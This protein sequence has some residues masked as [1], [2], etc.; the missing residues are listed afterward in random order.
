[1][2]GADRR[3]RFSTLE[4]TL[5]FARGL[6]RLLAQGDIVLLEG[7]LGAGKTELARAII[8]ELVGLPIAVPSPTFSLV[9]TYDAPHW[10]IA[11][12]DLYR[13][14]DP[15]EVVELG[16]EEFS[17]LGVLIV[18]WPSRAGEGVFPATAILIEM[19]D[20]GGEHREIY[21]RSSDEG[22]RHRLAVILDAA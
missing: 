6:A 10:P 21:L 14:G 12:A 9:Q 1:M 2:P 5:E 17:D 7:E 20:I 22:W 18:E 11:H 3:L 16:L 19:N 8:R 15:E 13:L 4:A